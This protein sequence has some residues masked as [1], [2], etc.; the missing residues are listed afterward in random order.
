[1][2]SQRWSGDIFADYNQ[3]YL[4]DSGC[5]NQAP[6]D[7]T[8]DDVRHRIKV[9]DH[10]VVIQPDRN[11]TV[12]VAI[13]V[14]DSEPTVDTHSWDHIAEASLHV[15]TGAL[16]IHEC[17]GGVVTDFRVASGWYRVRSLHANL[18]SVDGIEGKD[19]YLVQVW[20]SAE[21]SVAVLKQF[22]GD[23]ATR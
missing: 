16:Q 2:V 14:H 20:P 5:T 12:P 3:F 23:P 9:G 19:H 15:P 17:T 6:V 7:Y 8:D 13:E 1:V 21:R 4:W 10:V 22:G 11:F 18:G